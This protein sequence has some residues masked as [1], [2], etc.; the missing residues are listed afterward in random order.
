MSGMMQW[1]LA[2]QHLQVAEGGG[3]SQ[4]VPEL[5]E[6]HAALDA[7]LVAIETEL[8]IHHIIAAIGCF[9][10]SSHPEMFVHI[11][12]REKAVLG[13]QFRTFP[14]EVTRNTYQT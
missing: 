10:K 11:I 2:L 14:A 4:L 9:C 6:D 1:R 12:H 5:R 3:N 8:I 7:A 13:V